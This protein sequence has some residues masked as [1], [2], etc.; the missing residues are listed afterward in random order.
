M[1]DQCSITRTELSGGVMD[2]VRASR[3]HRRTWLS[4]MFS[5]CSLG[6]AVDLVTCEVFR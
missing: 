4:K 5:S 3:Q 6:L 1:G 2:G